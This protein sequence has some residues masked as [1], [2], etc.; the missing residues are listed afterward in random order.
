MLG[1]SCS[2]GVWGEWEQPYLT[3]NAE[4]EAAQLRV[5]AAMVAKGIIYRGRKP[6]HWSPSSR[7][8]LA[9]AVS[10]PS[11]MLPLAQRSPHALGQGITVSCQ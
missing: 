11:S 7:T 1:W 9:E 6:V 2:Y 4:Y 3:L 8:A 10:Q 5:F